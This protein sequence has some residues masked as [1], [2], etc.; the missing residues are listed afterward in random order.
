MKVNRSCKT[1][2]FNMFDKCGSKYYGE[3]IQ[4]FKLQ[5]DCWHISLDY[6]DK[7]AKKLPKEE[8]IMYENSMLYSINDLIN[9]IETGS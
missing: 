6:V 7:L 2:K 5:R 9:R 3:D 8:R 4:D 1:C